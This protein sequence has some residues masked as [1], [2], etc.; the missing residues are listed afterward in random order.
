M[1]ENVKNILK[2]DSSISITGIAGP[3]AERKEKPV[4]LVYISTFYKGKTIT[5]KEQF[6]GDR[7]SIREKSANVALYNLLR[8][9][10]NE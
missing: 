10:L 6:S 7:N 1:A 4:G 8:R 2:T 5:V 3:D 9:V